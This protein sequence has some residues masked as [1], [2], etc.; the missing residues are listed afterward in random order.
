[1]SNKRKIKIRPEITKQMKFLQEKPEDCIICTEKIKDNE[2][3]SCGHWIHISCIE[4]H[5][6]PECP[7][8]RKPQNI[9]VFG[10]I[11]EPYI[12]VSHENENTEN[13]ILSPL[14]SRIGIRFHLVTIPYLNPVIERGFIDNF[15]DL[16]ELENVED[17]YS[18]HREPF[19]RSFM[20]PWRIKGYMHPEEDEDYD[21]ENPNGDEVTY[22]DI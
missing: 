2:P 11:P 21:E 22:E 15:D 16:P 13:T 17:S 12:P 18:S 19:P 6:K 9:K 5:F 3:L 7:V 4:K 20:E 14:Y 1:M 10:K 8:C